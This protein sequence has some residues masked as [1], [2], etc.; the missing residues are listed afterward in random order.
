MNSGIALT[1]KNIY[2]AAL[3]LDEDKVQYARRQH[4]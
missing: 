2:S 4:K 3:E 1:I